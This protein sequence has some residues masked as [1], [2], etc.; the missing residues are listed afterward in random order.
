MLIVA[1]LLSL[2][3]QDEGMTAQ[4]T[5]GIFSPG[6]MGGA[7][8]RAWQQGGARVVSTVAGRSTRTRSLADSLQLVPSLAD[9][10]CNSERLSRP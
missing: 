3:R 8:G 10:L 2:R 1:L 5:I 4:V 7:L 9:G 6:A